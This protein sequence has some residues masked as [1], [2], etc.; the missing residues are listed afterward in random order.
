MS[1]LSCLIEFLFKFAD[2]TKNWQDAKIT[3]Q[4]KSCTDLAGAVLKFLDEIK[5]MKRWAIL[6]VLLYA[7]A[8]LVLTLPVV[9]IAFGNWG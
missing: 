3:F 8:L 4:K 6:T 2:E 1:P 7:L 5:T 9:L